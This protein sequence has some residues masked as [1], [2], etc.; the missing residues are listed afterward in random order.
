MRP[1]S[2]SPVIN[3]HKAPPEAAIQNMEDIHVSET[4]P[5]FLMFRPLLRPETTVAAGVGPCCH[6]RAPWIARGL[7]AEAA[8]ILCG[9]NVLVISCKD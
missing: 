7:E 3:L 5:S 6:K 2:S 9:L 8:I 1:H 4:S